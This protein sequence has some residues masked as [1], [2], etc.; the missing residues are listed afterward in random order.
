[1]QRENWQAA[2]QAVLADDGQSKTLPP[3]RDKERPE[4]KIERAR[5]T[6]MRT[7]SCLTDIDATHT[8]SSE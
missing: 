8:H 2:G 3:T 1:M 5:K 7:R 4:K 6:A